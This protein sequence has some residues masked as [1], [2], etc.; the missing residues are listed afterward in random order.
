LR[1]VGLQIDDSKA[2]QSFTLIY[3]ALA[4]Y[5]SLHG[6][7]LV[8]QLFKVPHGSPDYPST[9]WDM[10]LGAIVR[11]IRKKDNFASYRE[12]LVELGF[13]Y[14]AVKQEGH[15]PIQIVEID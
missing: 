3:T 1:D 12:Q 9:V 11:G 7:L 10:K 2:V 5:K 14:G 8:P 4:T 13:V 15:K 6:D